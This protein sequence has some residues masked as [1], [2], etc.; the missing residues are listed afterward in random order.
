MDIDLAKEINPMVPAHK[1]A[2]I[3]EINELWPYFE[4]QHLPERLAEVS[5]EIHDVALKLIRHL[6]AGGETYEGLRNLLVAKD[7]LVRAAMD[8]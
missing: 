6:P 7:C 3:E 2:Y 5:K 8:L 1:R 4:Y